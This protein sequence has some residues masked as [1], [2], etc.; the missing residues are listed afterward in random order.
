MAG[1]VTAGLALGCNRQ[2]GAG[3]GAPPE[4]PPPSV[5]VV[6]VT[7]KDVPVYL[8]EIGKAAALESVTITPR[9]QGQIIERLVEDGADVK[10]DQVLFKIDPRPTQAALEAAQAQAAQAK[11][12]LAFAN[13]ELERYQTVAG[14]RAISKS[15]VDTKKNAVDVAAAQLAAAEA[16]VRTAQLNLEYCT[17]RSPI[18]GRAGSRMVDVGNI[19]KE[20]ET[21]LL[22]IQKLDPIYVDFTV[23][24]QRLPAV[25]QNMANGTLETQ[26]RLPSQPDQP[27]V[28]SLTFLD[29][30]VQQAT[31]TVRL[32]ATVPN[33]DR[34]FWPG[35]FVNARL[36]LRTQK[37]ATLVPA[38]ALQ[39]GQAGTY[40]LVVKPDTTAELRTVV[41]GQEQGDLTV[42]EKG[43]AAG[44]QVIV[45]G[46]LMVRPGGKVMVAGGPDGAPGIAPPTTQNATAAASNSSGSHQ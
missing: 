23:N 5:S 16:A 22:S 43:V 36:V 21:A 8:D 19:V 33:A 1:M 6:A 7:T 18:D 42:I 27:R 39:L 24:E 28:G 13:I 45:Q 40:V 41:V 3:T 2:E 46:H 25:R 35:Q 9:I 44:E 15:D 38:T 20:N 17:V 31:G 4:M 32:R 34:L 12:A 30:T 37:D 10:K 11:A 26:V 14:T 29:N